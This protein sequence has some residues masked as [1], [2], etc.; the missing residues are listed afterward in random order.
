MKKK[1]GDIY[2]NQGLQPANQL[3][4]NPQM[5]QQGFVGTAINDLRSNKD[6]LNPIYDTAATIGIIY[7]VFFT[8]VI[9]IICS[10][11]IYMG[12]WLKNLNSNKSQSVKGKYSNVK[13]TNEIIED[14]NKNK[15]T[16]VNCTA[17]IIYSVNEKEYKKSHQV[18]H[19]IND[20]Q[21]VN[22]NYDPANPEDFSTDNNYYYFG[23]GLIVVGI[24]AIIIAIFWSIL[25]MLYKPIAAASGVGAIGDA[26]M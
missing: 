5:N 20:N 4:Q 17:D 9:I 21:P 14:A 25:S 19:T 16:I 24:L 11:M 1:G 6:V 2:Q 12:F 13:C 23:I 26:I 8:F 10:I 7:N 15:N 3:Y 18:T 22:V